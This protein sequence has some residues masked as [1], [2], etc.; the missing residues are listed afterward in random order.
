MMQED[1]KNG[2]DF[3][4]EM[5][6]KTMPPEGAPEVNWCRYVIGKGSSRIEGKKP[7][8]LQAVT[9]HAEAV[10]ENLNSRKA[11]YGS[12]YVYGKRN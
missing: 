2:N 9:Q 3:C 7:G 10:A 12:M 11:S 6:E 1:D 5:V 4:V 8:S